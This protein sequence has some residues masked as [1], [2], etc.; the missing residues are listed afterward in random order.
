MA[1][2]CEAT[3]LHISPLHFQHGY[4]VI[5]TWR[6]RPLLYSSLG[7]WANLRTVEFW[8]IQCLS[9]PLE[10]W[11]V[12][13]IHEFRFPRTFHKLRI[14]KLGLQIRSKT[15]D[16]FCHQNKNLHELIRFVE[17]SSNLRISRVLLTRT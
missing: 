2:T 1:V 5:D 12:A 9:L 16:Q 15:R 3:R 8:W 17:Y 6:R 14:T 13:Y 4:G 7:L 11:E 10:G